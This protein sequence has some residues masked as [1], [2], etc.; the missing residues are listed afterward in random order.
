[1]PNGELKLQDVGLNSEQVK[2]SEMIS[3]PF[4]EMQSL[5]EEKETHDF[6]FVAFTDDGLSNGYN[7]SLIVIKRKGTEAYYR[8]LAI[9]YEGYLT[10]TKASRVFPVTTTFTRESYTKIL[11]K[12]KDAEIIRTLSSN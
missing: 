8:F 6:E 12:E 2:V 10:F 9:S 5:Y 11:D 7:R 4:D 1:M 3:L